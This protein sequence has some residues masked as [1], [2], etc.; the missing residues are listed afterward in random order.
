MS[1]SG[2]RRVCDCSPRYGLSNDMLHE[3][4]R[5]FLEELECIQSAVEDGEF[6]LSNPNLDL[7]R[8]H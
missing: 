7:V 3:V 6:P 5:R 8:S 1:P 2:A 4:F